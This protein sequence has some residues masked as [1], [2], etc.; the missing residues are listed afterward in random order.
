M[1]PKPGGNGERVGNGNG[2]LAAMTGPFGGGARPRGYASSV[3]IA[4]NSA[5]LISPSP[6][7]S[8][9]SI[10]ACLFGQ[11]SIQELWRVERSK[12][13]TRILPEG[14]ANWKEGTRTGGL[15]ARRPLAGLQSPSLRG[16]GSLG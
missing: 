12:A 10:I 8:N 7:R 3:M 16:E 1:K 15:T 2:A 5:S 6:S 9:S 14:V 11:T 4:K 13:G